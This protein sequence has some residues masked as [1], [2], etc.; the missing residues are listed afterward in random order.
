MI[1]MFVFYALPL[2]A[3]VKDKQQKLW[4]NLIYWGCFILNIVAGIVTK[5]ETV[6]II[7][8]WVD[9][10]VF[11]AISIA[12]V[13]KLYQTFPASRTEES[14]KSRELWMFIGS[15]FLLLSA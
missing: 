5:N 6:F 2:F 11:I 9:V 8:K 1:F 10:A 15:L 12:F 3:I 13:Y 4:L 7:L 14:F